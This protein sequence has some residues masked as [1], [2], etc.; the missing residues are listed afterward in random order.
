MDARVARGRRDVPVGYALAILGLVVATILGAFAFQAAGY[1]PCELCLKERLPYYAGMA[2]AA[3][4]VAFAW[5]GPAMA[6]RACF[7]LLALLFLFSAGFGGNLA[8]L[9]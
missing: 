7:V 1:A 4:A 9:G 6:W 5:R 8:V 3:V 2:L